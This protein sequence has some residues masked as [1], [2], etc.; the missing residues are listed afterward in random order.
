MASSLEAHT[1]T[2]RRFPVAVL[3]TMPIYE[4]IYHLFSNLC[5]SESSFRNDRKKSSRALLME[6]RMATLAARE[7]GGAGWR[8][9]LGCGRLHSEGGAAALPSARRTYGSYS[10]LAHMSANLEAHT[11]FWLHQR[12]IRLNCAHITRNQHQFNLLYIVLNS[13][14]SIWN[15][16]KA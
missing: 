8:R 7:G 2:Q 4:I 6:G 14:S 13:R 11:L 16:R 3:E 12:S 9:W 1:H 10:R 15:L 5:Y